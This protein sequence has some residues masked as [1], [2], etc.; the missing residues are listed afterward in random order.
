MIKI[1]DK[2][3]CCGCS[4]CFNIC[5]RQAISMVADENGFKYPIVDKEKCINCGM[6]ERICPYLN[7]STSNSSLDSIKVYGGWIKDE[8]ERNNSTSGGIFTALSKWIIKNNGVVCGAAFD[9][10][11]NVNHILVDNEGD[12][13][14]LNGSKYVQS[15]IGECFK[16]IKEYLIKDRYVLFSGTPCQA[17]GLNNYLGK[18]YEKLF[19]CDIVCHGVPSPKVFNKYKNDLEKQ[20]NSKLVN[21]NF[22]NKIT[23]WDK[24][25]FSCEF[26]NTKK[27][28]VKASDNDYMKLFLNDIDLRETCPIC[29]FAKLPREVDFT[30]G[31]F[32]GCNESY[33]ELNK[34]DKGVS[35]ILV[36]SEKGDK[37]LNALN[38]VFLQKCDLLKSIKYNPSIIKHKPA[39]KNRNKFFDFIDNNSIHFLSKKYVKN[40]L[41][42]KILNKVKNVVSKYEK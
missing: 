29:K 34:D 28:Y 22:R 18:Q 12:L 27:L 9:D 10:E 26:K 24:Y 39:N 17:I 2:S 23:G 19:I 20:E 5:P 21:I 4:A 36:Y 8:T 15:N 40:G 30:L 41:L 25:S 14:K 35:L 11:L 32:W 37:L 42:R 38:D 1:E 7:N 33:P 16:K 13:K 31:D 3:K 6:C